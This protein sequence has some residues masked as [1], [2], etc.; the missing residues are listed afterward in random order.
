VLTFYLCW[1]LI[2]FT[3][4][5]IAATLVAVMAFAWERRQDRR[6][7]APGIGLA[8]ALVQAI[9]GLASGSTVAYFAPAV[10]VNG[11]YGLAFLVSIAIRRPLAGVLAAETYP[12]PPEI[13]ASESF[14]QI[15]TRVSLVWA[16]FLLLRAGVRWVILTTASLDVYIA[17]S[18]ATGFP[19]T[20]AMMTWSIWY[21]V[22]R[23]QR[24]LGVATSPR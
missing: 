19:L 13:K 22:R 11:V 10:I 18:L 15:F 9:A 20:A 14:R 1:K 16:I 21:S 7:L 4:G 23:F 24:E 5:V 17:V 2:G 3:T 8:I 6:G 12:F